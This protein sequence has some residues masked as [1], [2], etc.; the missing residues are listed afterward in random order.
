VKN[1]SRRLGELEKR[2]ASG[3]DKRLLSLLCRSC[4]ED[5]EARAEI[6]RLVAASKGGSGMLN[7][8]DVILLGL[9]EWRS[10]DG[11]EE[12]SIKSDME[13]TNA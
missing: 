7:L 1:I 2:M 10:E 11:G 4:A 12:G 9:D 5:A 13:V 8:C 3:D 6:E